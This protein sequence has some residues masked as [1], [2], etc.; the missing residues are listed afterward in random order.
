[1]IHDSRLCEELA[2][3]QGEPL[4][5]MQSHRGVY[6]SQQLSLFSLATVQEL[7]NE[8]NVEIDHRQFR[9]N[10]Y[11]QPARETA[12][13]IE[14]D[15]V[16]RVLRIGPDALIGVTEK[17]ERCL[18]VNLDPHS[19]VQSPRIL[20]SIAQKHNEE[21]GI[22]ANVLRSGRIRIGDVIEFE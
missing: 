6:D 7:E 4:S 20:R 3:V 1:M 21:A 8:S 17:N 9:A 22:Y 12:P 2:H 13:F 5:L 14:N 19:A 15:W 18:V 16:G 11:F 10:V